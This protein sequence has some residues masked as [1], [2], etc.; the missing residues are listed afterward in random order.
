MGFDP[1][2]ANLIE[3]EGPV[4]DSNGYLLIAMC[5]YG[6][7]RDGNLTTWEYNFAF[8][9]TGTRKR[10]I[11][12]LTAQG[13]EILREFEWHTENFEEWLAELVERAGS[14]ERPT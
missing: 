14:Y 7:V 3:A 9:A 12:Q 2:V 6:E 10:G 5:S 11:Y 1:R 4:V 8:D 13:G